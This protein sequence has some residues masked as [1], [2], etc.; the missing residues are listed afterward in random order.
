MPDALTHGAHEIG[1]VTRGRRWSYQPVSFSVPTWQSWA[2]AWCWC[3]PQFLLPPIGRMAFGIAYAIAAAV[4]VIAVFRSSDGKVA[5][6]GRPR[7]S[8]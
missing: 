6:A 8:D 5:P 7:S 3:C 1:P 2:S 4:L